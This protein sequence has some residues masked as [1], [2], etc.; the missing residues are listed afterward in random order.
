MRIEM[1]MYKIIG[2]DPANN[3][4]FHYR[5]VHLVFQYLHNLLFDCLLSDQLP[6]RHT[7]PGMFFLFP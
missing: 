5:K 3:Y 2:N 6:I 4:R 1:M 7:M